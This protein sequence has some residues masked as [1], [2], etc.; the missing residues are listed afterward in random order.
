[1]LAGPFSGKSARRVTPMPT[2]AGRDLGHD[3]FD[4]SKMQPQPSTRTM[5]AWGK[6]DGYLTT[7]TACDER[8]SPK[9]L[10]AWGSQVSQAGG[11]VGGTSLPGRPLCFKRATEIQTHV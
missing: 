7:L 3:I 10:E 2:F 1:M 4:A 11:G 8:K 9:P 5:F 6:F